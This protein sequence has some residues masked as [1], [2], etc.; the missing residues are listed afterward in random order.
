MTQPKVINLIIPIAVQNYVKTIKL[1]DN[2]LKGTSAWQALN[3]IAQSLIPDRMSDA[4]TE[5]F[6]NLVN[7]FNKQLQ[8][9]TNETID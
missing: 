3:L 4:Q 8:Q 2:Q 1:R 5:Q 9:K 6:N 7:N